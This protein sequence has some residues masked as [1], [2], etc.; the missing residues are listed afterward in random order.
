MGV[1]LHF[2]GIAENTFKIVHRPVYFN[3]YLQNFLYSL[4]ACFYICFT[5][6]KYSEPVKKLKGL[7]SND[8]FD[9]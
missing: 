1:V 8:E 6:R 7:P 2:W 5:H 3:L 9:I 4:S